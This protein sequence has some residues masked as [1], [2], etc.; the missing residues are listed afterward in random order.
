MRIERFKL[1]PVSELSVLLSQYI[2]T[3]SLSQ[4]RKITVNT[5]TK[6]TATEPPPG[7]NSQS[8]SP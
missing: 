6:V 8:L 7:Q 1:R 5:V 4:A 3:I 2:S